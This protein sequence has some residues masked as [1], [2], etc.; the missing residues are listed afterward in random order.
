MSGAPGAL[1]LIQRVYADAS[2]TCTVTTGAKPQAHRRR[3]LLVATIDLAFCC[4]QLADALSPSYP[5][6][7]LRL[8][9]QP[10]LHL[11]ILAYACLLAHLT[12]PTRLA[13]TIRLSLRARH[14]P[15][16]ALTAHHSGYTE[17]FPS[18]Q[19]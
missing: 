8:V 9:S 1:V 7:A 19:V 10:C 15:V 16:R 3:S 12:I 6:L 4:S 13:T 14:R 17:R 2:L 18:S 5:H 11:G